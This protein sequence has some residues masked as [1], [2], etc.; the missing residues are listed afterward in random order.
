MRFTKMAKRVDLDLILD[1]FDAITQQALQYEQD[2]A[3]EAEALEQQLV[4]VG[5][6]QSRLKRL[7]NTLNNTVEQ[8]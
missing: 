2:L 7:L 3:D 8:E 6:K 4:E 1:Q 5:K